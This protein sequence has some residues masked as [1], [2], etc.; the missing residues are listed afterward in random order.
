MAQE[1]RAVCAVPQESAE[2]SRALR[3]LLVQSLARAL[4]ISNGAT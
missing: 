1:D 3:G 4:A 2:I